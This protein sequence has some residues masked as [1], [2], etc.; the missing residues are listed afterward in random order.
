[1]LLAI[2]LLACGELE[3]NPPIE[4][5]V[6]TESV[7]E[8][9]VLPGARAQPCDAAALFEERL[10]GAELPE[11]DFHQLDRFLDEPT[12]EDAEPIWAALDR[13]RDTLFALRDGSLCQRVGVVDEDMAP[14]IR[15]GGMLLSAQAE[16]FALEG[17]HESAVESALQMWALGQDLQAGSVSGVTVGQWFQATGMGR[18]DGSIPYM[19]RDVMEGIVDDVQFLVHREP[20]LKRTLNA[21][22]AV[23]RS[24]PGGVVPWPFLVGADAETAA[25][26]CSDDAQIAVDALQGSSPLPTVDGLLVWR[27]SLEGAGPCAQSVIAWTAGVYPTQ[28]E[29][30][31]RSRTLLL[32]AALAANPGE[33]PETLEELAVLDS[34]PANPVTGL[35]MAYDPVGCAVGYEAVVALEAW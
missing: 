34:V 2:L 27:E 18:I 32:E 1:M 31:I 33:C 25:E 23:L 24:E 29:L 14:V 11:R 3:P 22:V 15:D 5:M 17:D 4:Q 9:P 6:P 35:P 19:D 30:A 13:H 12:E 8:R 16:L 20:G 26:R 10:A 7:W 21:Q 28:L